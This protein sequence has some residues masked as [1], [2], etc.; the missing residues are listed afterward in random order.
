MAISDGHV[1]YLPLEQLWQLYWHWGWN[2][3]SKRPGT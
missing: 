2:L 3:P 1:Q